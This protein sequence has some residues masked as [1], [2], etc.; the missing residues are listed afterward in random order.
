M[1]AHKWRIFSP[2]SKESNGS[3]VL[4]LRIQILREVLRGNY[5]YSL[6]SGF[7]PVEIY[8]DKFANIV[9]VI[10][11]EPLPNKMSYVYQ[12]SPLQGVFVILPEKELEAE[13]G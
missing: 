10:F 5:V 4:Y 7:M 13:G 1:C 9:A 8:T 3:S 11:W 6:P 12:F 2:E